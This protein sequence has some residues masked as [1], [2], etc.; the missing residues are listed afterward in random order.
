MLEESGERER[1]RKREKEGG[2][3]EKEGGKREKEGGKREK[4][5]GGGGGGGGGGER[6]VYM[7][8]SIHFWSESFALYRLQLVHNVP[9]CAG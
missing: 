9:K 2:K 3:R 4:E 6:A 1:E 7:S 8:E 5:V